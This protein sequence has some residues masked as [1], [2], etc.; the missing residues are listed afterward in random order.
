M[1]PAYSSNAR[2]LV[3]SIRAPQTGSL[4]EALS[5]PD[6]LNVVMTLHLATM[7]SGRTWTAVTGG[8]AHRLQAIPHCRHFVGSGWCTLGAWAIEGFV[9]GPGYSSVRPRSISSGGRGASSNFQSHVGHLLQL[10]G[11]TFG[12][13]H[14]R[15]R[16][17]DLSITPQ[18]IPPA[19]RESPPES[20]LR[21]WPRHLQLG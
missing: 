8:H 14:D 18:S 12:H 19:S 13:I 17:Y 10:C 4:S 7:C 6:E 9:L 3:A 15:D 11:S 20:G 1:L 2:A 21:S 5:L 16:R